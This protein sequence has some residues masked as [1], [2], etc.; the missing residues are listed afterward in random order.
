MAALKAVKPDPDRLDPVLLA[1]SHARALAWTL[2][3][4][5]PLGGPRNNLT[6]ALECGPPQ[7]RGWIQSTLS[8][9]LREWHDTIERE[10][11]RVRGLSLKP[12][13]SEKDGA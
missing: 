6:D 1:V 2:D 3:M 13:A 8:E 5:G 7:T 12:L 4:L 11:R 9:A 10:Y